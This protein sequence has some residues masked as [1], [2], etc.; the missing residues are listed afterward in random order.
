MCCVYWIINHHP[1][2]GQV[3][4]NINIFLLT[5]VLTCTTVFI[6]GSTLL[7]QIMSQIWQV[8]GNHILRPRLLLLFIQHA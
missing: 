2:R 3:R 1:A 7:S 4:F 6:F 8:L 5:L